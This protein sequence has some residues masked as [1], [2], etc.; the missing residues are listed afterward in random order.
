MERAVSIL[1]ADDL[2]V[3][4]ELSAS[5]LGFQIGFEAS[6]DGK[7]GLLGLARGTIQITLDSLMDGHGQNAC[8]SARSR[9]RG[10]VL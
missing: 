1:P 8:V 3:A 2:G 6:G 7:T 5:K 4:K 9:Q 10:C